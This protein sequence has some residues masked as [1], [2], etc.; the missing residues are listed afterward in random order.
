MKRLKNFVAVA[1]FAAALAALS[2]HM[3]KPA[4]PILDIAAPEIQRSITLSGNYLA[5]RFAQRQQDW[6]AAQHYIN[7]VLVYDDSNI[8]LSERAF[9]L[10]LGAEQY[11]RARDLAQKLVDASNKSDLAYIYLASD[12]LSRDD[13]DGALALLDKLPEDGFGQYTKPL[14]TAWTYAGQGKYDEALHLLATRARPKDPTYNIHSALI[15]EMAGR[16]EDA[17]RHYRIAIDTGLTMHA[18]VLSAHFFTRQGEHETAEKIY[19]RLGTLYPMNTFADAAGAG[20]PNV[21]RA[22]EGAGIALFDL[23]TLL[24]EKRAY[25]SAQVY[26]SLVQLL[27]PSSPF[28]LMML[29]DIAALN[30]QYSKALTNYNAVKPSSPLYWFSRLRVAEIDEARGRPELAEKLLIDLAKSTETRTPALVTLGDLYRRQSRFADA[31]RVYDEALQK[32]PAKS[33]ETW[34]ILYAR[35]MA[36]ERSGHWPRAEEDLL[37]ALE[38]QPDNA[39]ILNFIGYSWVEKGVNLKRALEF[40]RRAVALRPNDGYILDSYGWALF[41][42]GQRAD[43]VKWLERAVEEIPDDSTILDH[44]GDAYWHTGRVNEARFKWRRATEV[45][46]DAAFK[47]EMRKKIRHGLQEAPTVASHDDTKI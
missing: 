1:F 26:G 32:V 2:Q 12:A 36:L 14:L 30:G 28:V 19:R 44:L 4:A 13:F 7:E 24:Y 29:G 43:A 9:L 21:T 6:D 3:Q 23:A 34:S 25:D 17:A 41:R 42:N 18:A 15:E 33:A 38:M 11:S 8:G 22:A 27:Y 16:N 37:T 40:T 10:S 45:S 46:K 20:R 35:G 47:D 39:M 31:I 5:G